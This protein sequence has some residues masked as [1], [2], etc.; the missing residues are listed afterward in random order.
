MRTTRLLAV[1]MLTAV[2]VGGCTT[3]QVG[4]API[5]SPDTSVPDTTTPDTTTPAPDT[6]TPAPDITAPAPATTLAP[7]SAPPTTVPGPP[8]PGAS[9]IPAGADISATIHGDIDGDLADDTVTEY[10][11]KGVPHVHSLLAN[12]GESDVAVQIGLADHVTISFEDFDYA[13][14]AVTKPAVAVLAVGATKAGTAVYTFLTNTVHY[15]IQ[16]WHTADGK[17][18]TGRLASDGPY[19]GLSCDTSAGHR[20]YATNKAVQNA[21]GTWKVTQTVFHHNFTLI[22]F[23]K[24]LPS[25]TVP[26]D[27]TVRHLYGDFSNCD[28]PPL[29]P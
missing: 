11:L 27:P 29:F 18:W 20:F 9:G 4:V 3:T 26:D 24:P 25:I 15:C 1:T 22:K 28:H 7:A 14:G 21:S 12:G 16:P 6:T 2:L 23:D 17:M 8:C 5:T 10:S 19:E 13:L